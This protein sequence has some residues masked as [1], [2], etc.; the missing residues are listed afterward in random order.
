[1]SSDDY[2]FLYPYKPSQALPII[3][4]VIILALS[5]V[6]VYQAFFRYKWFHFGLMF[7]WASLV[8]VTG[9]ICRALAAYNVNNIDLYICQ[10]VLLL[11][12]P[13]LYAASEYFILGRLLAYV[14]YHAP[15]Q[16]GRVL[17]TF[18]FLSAAV[19]ALTASGSA[20]VAKS[21]Q[22]SSRR[23]AGLNLV[24][25]GLLL[26]SVVELCFLWL[27]VLVEYRCRKGGQ[28]TSRV[29]VTCYLLYT[30]SMMMLVRCI[31]RAI[32]GFQEADCALSNPNCSFIDRHEWFLWVFEVANITV[33]ITA[34]A[35]FYPG[36]Y[37]PRDS[38]IFQD[39]FDPEIER[40]GPGFADATE[41]SFVATL[42]DPFDLVGIFSGAAATRIDKFWER[43]NPIAQKPTNNSPKNPYR[44]S[45]VLE[46]VR[47]RT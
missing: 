36:R 16:P 10:Y 24:K 8:W 43:D 31:F 5:L 14:P 2:S 47:S 20:T 39:F 27:T 21:S 12:G 1:M 9:F 13:V 45:W 7:L 25:A 3:F 44:I 32:Q 28:W 29:R 34:L 41:R 17:S 33:F 40:V 30:T 42:L 26:Q 11:A 18:L 15:I 46:R 19:E 4:G 22:T 38:N 6:H 23:D 35:I 37:I